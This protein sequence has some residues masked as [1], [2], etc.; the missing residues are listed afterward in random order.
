LIIGLLARLAERIGKEVDDSLSCRDHRRRIL[1]RCGNQCS[2][3]TQIV[4][5]S[6]HARGCGHILRDRNQVPWVLESI[7]EHDF[8]S[9]QIITTNAYGRLEL[10]CTITMMRLSGGCAHTH[11]M[12][13]SN[14]YQVSCLEF[15]YHTHTQRQRDRERT[16][17]ESKLI[18]MTA[19]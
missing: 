12:Y 8:G 9:K 1:R 16:S 3:M 13:W 10:H 11:R 19:T 17:Q 18:D 14:P 6:L 7:G 15:L 2:A 4:R 5:D